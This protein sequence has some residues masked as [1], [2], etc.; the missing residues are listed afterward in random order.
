MRNVSANIL[1]A[2]LLTTA[3]ASTSV[4]HAGGVGVVLNGGMHGSNVAA[5]GYGDTNEQYV[6][7]QPLTNYGMGLQAV[8]GDRDDR[9]VGTARFYYRHVAAQSADGVV[10]DAKADGY[11]GTADELVYTLEPAEDLGYATVGVQWGLWGEP[12]G[13]QV[14]LLTNIGAVFMTDDSREKLMVELGPGVHYS[15]TRELQFNVEALYQMQFRKTDPVHGAT[16][17]VGARWMFD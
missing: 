4:A 15:L 16:I 14:N 11:E 7:G 1:G 3:F 5:Y 6:L 13:F 17:N 8:L 12:A 9:F 2:A 10:A